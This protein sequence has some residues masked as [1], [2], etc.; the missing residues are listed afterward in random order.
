MSHFLNV[1]IATLEHP[2]V[3]FR[4]HLS[5][6]IDLW[7]MSKKPKHSKESIKKAILECKGTPIEPFILRKK[8]FYISSNTLNAGF[9][10][11]RKSKSSQI[12]E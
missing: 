5:N 4:E 7:I 6:K 12:N 10:E 8:Q 2:D 1:L 3:A 9:H 11:R